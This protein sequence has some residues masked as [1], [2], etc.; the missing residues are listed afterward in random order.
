MV[1]QW[2]FYEV[3]GFFM[4]GQYVPLAVGLALLLL[5]IAVRRRRLV[6]GLLGFA[7]AAS[8]LYAAIYTF[9]ML[10]LCITQPPVDLH[11]HPPWR[12]LCIIVVLV[13]GLVQILIYRNRLSSSKVN[14]ILKILVRG[15]YVLALGPL[16]WASICCHG[17]IAELMIGSQYVAYWLLYGWLEAVVF[18]AFFAWAAV[19]D[20]VATAWFL[21]R[22]CWS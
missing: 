21:R 9:H 10:R 17:G 19:V 1:D 11:M 2:F 14:A 20:A 3:N 16:C 13:Y 5:R 4:A 18:A 22:R 15:S 12:H 6:W 8:F 7:S